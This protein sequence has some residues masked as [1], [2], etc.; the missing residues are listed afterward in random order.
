MRV[1]HLSLF[2]FLIVGVSLLLIAQGN[3]SAANQT[4]DFC[5]LHLLYT[6]TEGDKSIIIEGEEGVIVTISTRDGTILGNGVITLTGGQMCEG[7]AEIPLSQ[8][9]LANTILVIQGS[10][11]TRAEIMVA[12]FKISQFQAKINCDEGDDVEVRGQDWQ[13]SELITISAIDPNG[14]PIE[15]GSTIPVYGSFREQFLLPTELLS[16]DLIEIVAEGGGERKH[17]FVTTNCELVDPATALHG[18]VYANIETEWR[19]VREAPLNIYH[20]ELGFFGHSFADAQGAFELFLPPT[21]NP[22]EIQGCQ[23]IDG[24]IYSGLVKAFHNSQNVQLTLN[25]SADGSCFSLPPTVDNELTPIPGEQ[26]PFLD[27]L[28]EFSDVAVSPPQITLQ[29]DNSA[30]V[31]FTVTNL[32]AIAIDYRFFVDLYVN[33]PQNNQEFQPEQSVGYQ[34]I[35]FLAPSASITVTIPIE[36]EHS[37]DR[38]Q[39]VW[40][41]ADSADFVLEYDEQN[42]IASNT[43]IPPRPIQTVAI[44]ALAFDH[45]SYSASNL[46][47]QFSATIDGILSA[48]IAAPTKLAVVLADLEQDGDTLIVVA[49]NGVAQYIHGLPDQSGLLSTTIN[50]YD[51]SDG[52]TLGGFLLWA[53]K[54]YPTPNTIFSF[55]GHGLPLMPDESVETVFPPTSTVRSAE[56]DPIALP[57]WVFASPDYTDTHPKSIIS[58][59]DLATA[60]AKGSENGSRPFAVVDLAHCF[61]LSIEELFE[62]ALYTKSVIGSPS[63]NYFS[64]ELPGVALATIQNGE[65]PLEMATGLINA[66][67]Q[68]LPSEA[69]PRILT[70]VDTSRLRPIKEWWDLTSQALLTEL[71]NYSAET[72]SKIVIAYQ[73][74][75]KYD[76]TGCQTDWQLA[77]PDALSDFYSFADELSR[78]FVNTPVADYADKTRQ[79]IDLAIISTT[80][81][82]GIPYFAQGSEEVWEFTG[83]GISIYTDFLGSRNADGQIALSW[84]ANWYDDSIAFLAGGA[85]DEVFGRFWDGTPYTTAKCLTSFPPTLDQGELRVVNLISPDPNETWINRPILPGIV[86]ESDSPLKNALVTLSIEQAGESVYS[87]TLSTGELITETR[88]IM[89]DVAWTPTQLGRYT[90]TITIDPENFVVETSETDNQLIVTG[91]VTDGGDRPI[92]S[93]FDLAQDGQ[94]VTNPNITLSVPVTPTARSEENALIDLYDFASFESGIG[95]FNLVT[96]STIPLTTQQI[97]LT[98]PPDTAAGLIQLHIKQTQTGVTTPEFSDVRFNYIPANTPISQG[99]IICY[100]FTGQRGDHLQVRLDLPDQENANLFL[101]Y[102]RNFAKPDKIGTRQGD[103]ELLISYAPLNGEYLLCVRGES[104]Q[105][106]YTLSFL[107]NRRDNI[108]VHSTQQENVATAYIPQVRIFIDKALPTKETLPTAITH[109]QESAD[110]VTPW[111]IIVGTMT[112]IGYLSWLAF[113]KKISQQFTH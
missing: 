88:F 111:T 68:A 48:T 17:S 83:K 80:R 67:D 18:L 78:V 93:E 95:R 31:N 12:P 9:L 104:P 66:Y 1:I 96:Q 82:S 30:L 14:V 34:E 35:P 64:A 28:P 103:D 113:G 25:E 8:P 53:R 71:T 90:V 6:P 109:Q 72:K 87:T 59:R 26:A 97:H 11:R 63:Y 39:T 105:T 33:D 102:P 112:L 101:W 4:V 22:Y 45:P 3:S 58:P 70:A 32:S 69:Y 29:Q 62:I 13:T 77:P 27:P 74:S 50:E 36:L 73:N 16:L 54:N 40:V 86:I 110:S 37:F 42:N 65:S 57:S 89:G 23:E 56:T 75:A 49:Q 92:L 46:A 41:Y 99:Q 107:T 76:T 21:N 91:L 2:L 106:T 5:A 52:A 20:P 47:P 100:P 61:A 51:M 108:V 38:A 55:I 81:Q 24:K 19:P 84:Q 85:W 43:V 7:S 98:L 15:L 10:D 60:L 79:A 94:W 44:Y